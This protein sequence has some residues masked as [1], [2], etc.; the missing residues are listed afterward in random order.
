MM[1]SPE[2]ALPPGAVRGPHSELPVTEDMQAGPNHLLAGGVLEGIPALFPKGAQTGEV[3]R[4]VRTQWVVND[5]LS[6]S[7]LEMGP[8]GRG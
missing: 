6:H 7:E 8:G 1:F 5:G 4:E 2:K 3:G